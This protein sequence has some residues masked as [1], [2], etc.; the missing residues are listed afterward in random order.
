M[1]ITVTPFSENGGFAA[2]AFFLF[3]PT[4][5]TAGQSFISIYDPS[6]F[7]DPDDASS[8]SWRAE[9]IEV[10]RVPTIHRVILVYRD[11]GLAT[12]TVTVSGVNDNGATVTAS[13]L[14]KIGSA[15]ASNNLMTAF[16]DLT[17]SAFRPQLSIS[18][19]AGAGPVSIVSATMVGEVEE[20]SF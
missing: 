14:T 5:T 20:V 8:Y 2:T 1:A 15:A 12:I 17:V 9:D 11:L 6:N 7:D 18:R 13:K 3:V 16:V 19:A 10:A 4:T